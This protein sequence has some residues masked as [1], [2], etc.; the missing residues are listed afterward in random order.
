M[1]RIHGGSAPARG[2]SSFLGHPTV[3]VEHSGDCSCDSTHS[4]VPHSQHVGRPCPR[5]DPMRPRRPRARRPIPHVIRR[6]RRPGDVDPEIAGPDGGLLRHGAEL[7]D[8]FF[9][10]GKPTGLVLAEDRFAVDDDVEHTATALDQLGLDADFLLDRSRQTGGIGVVVSFTA[11]GDRDGH[12]L[13][14]S[15][16]AG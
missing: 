13:N 6:R 3:S 5:T 12:A 10:L 9:G 1:L 14:S 16:I 15:R 8:D 2:L 4:P 7:A 11:V